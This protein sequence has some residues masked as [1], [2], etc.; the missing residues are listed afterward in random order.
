MIK[1]PNIKIIIG[2][3]ILVALF[4]IISSINLTKPKYSAKDFA[5]ILKK[6]SDA[7]ELIRNIDSDKVGFNIVKLDKRTI[8]IE[9]YGPYKE[10]YQ[11]LPESDELYRVRVLDT[12]KKRGLL[13]VIDMNNKKVLKVY[14]LI[15]LEIDLEM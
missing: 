5:E 1:R 12:D 8:E 14:G 11:D 4:L 6:N 13:T 9:Q 10:L 2:I 3:G 15:N 7:Q